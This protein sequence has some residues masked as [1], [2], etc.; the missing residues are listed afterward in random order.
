MMYWP[1]YVDRIQR[2]WM[3]LARAQIDAMTT[4]T[5]R[6][7]I[8]ANRDT[9]RARRR[10]DREARTMVS[11]KVAALLAGA[12]DASTTMMRRRRTRSDDFATGVGVAVDATRAFV[13]PAV[14]RVARNARRLK[15]TAVT[16]DRS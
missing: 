11:E 10:S 16:M 15:K 13:A 9:P 14:R 2:L 1:R 3:D 6:L 7:T 5:C 4:I 8:L 12:R